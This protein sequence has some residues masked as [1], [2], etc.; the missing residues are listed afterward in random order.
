MARYKPKSTVAKALLNVLD[1]EK[2]PDGKAWCL[3]KGNSPGPANRIPALGLSELQ[4]GIHEVTTWPLKREAMEAQD[5]LLEA[6][7]AVVGQQP[8][9][10]EEPAETVYR[11]ALAHLA[12]E[13][14]PT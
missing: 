2:T 6:I 7:D 9:L 1:A 14:V 3:V 5:A 4:S 13:L 12:T 11:A 10:A 8:A